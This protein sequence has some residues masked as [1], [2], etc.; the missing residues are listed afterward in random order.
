VKNKRSTGTR[1]GCGGRRQSKAEAEVRI[2]SRRQAS[3]KEHTVLATSGKAKQKGH[4]RREAG[5]AAGGG[6]RK[7]HATHHT[8]GSRVGGMFRRQAEKLSTIGRGRW[9]GEVAPTEWR[10]S[11]HRNTEMPAHARTCQAVEQHP[12]CVCVVESPSN[13]PCENVGAEV[14][15]G[16]EDQC[17]EGSR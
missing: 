15:A 8:R 5:S 4:K 14:V 9:V 6:S 3:R 12:H 11:H 1:E 16:M 13:P 2:K 17:R 7:N 10:Q